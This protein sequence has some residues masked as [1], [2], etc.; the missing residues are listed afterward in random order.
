M[1]GG[2]S[3][4]SF[5]SACPLPASISPRQRRQQQV[6]ERW[7]RHP[8]SAR[9]APTSRRYRGPQPLPPFR[10][11]PRSHNLRPPEFQTTA[12]EFETAAAAQPDSQ[13]YGPDFMTATISH[14][15]LADKWGCSVLE[16]DA[17]NNWQ[18]V[19]INLRG[20]V[21]LLLLTVF[22]RHRTIFR[23]AYSQPS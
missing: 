20:Q 5:G 4:S 19:D 21:L 14:E 10:P 13:P 15:T 22:A 12:A 1:E 11:S 3:A 7:K 23:S 18:S 9:S 16:G 17:Y 6:A 2:S 8:Q